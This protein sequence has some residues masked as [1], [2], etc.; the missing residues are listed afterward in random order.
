MVEKVSTQWDLKN[1]LESTPSLKQIM[2]NIDQVVW[3][4]DPKTGA[5]LY[6]SPA[7]ASVWGRSRQSL[8][9]APQILI[10]SVHPEDRLQVMV[11]RQ[12]YADQP[13]TQAYRILRPDGVLRWIFV[14]TF[15]IREE[16][17]GQDLLINVAED[18][19]DQKQVDLALRKTLDRTREQFDLSR[20][21]SLARK[22]EAVLK[23]LMSAHELRLAQR[24]ALVFFADPKVGSAHGV[25]IPTTWLSTLMFHHGR[26]NLTCMKSQTY[27]SFYKQIGRW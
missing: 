13:T 19:T 14:R 5:I 12:Y 26:A 21:M 15:L 18:V 4:T 25:E 6:V 20:K 23:T 22:P 16:A 2:Q 10:E 7:F 11:A 8:L 3:I 9:A 17:G 1:L 27:G 24:A